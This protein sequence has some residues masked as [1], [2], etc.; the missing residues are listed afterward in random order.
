MIREFWNRER[1]VLIYNSNVVAPGRKTD[2]LLHKFS[3]DE[4]VPPLVYVVNEDKDLV[5]RWTYTGQI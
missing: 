1:V 3:H 2:L 5:E 4:F